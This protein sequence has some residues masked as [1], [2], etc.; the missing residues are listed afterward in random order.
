LHLLL[1]LLQKVDTPEHSALSTAISSTGAQAGGGGGGGSS[2][3]QQIYQKR[4]SSMLRK[5]QQLILT[6]FLKHQSL[7]AVLRRYRTL[8]DFQKPPPEEAQNASSYAKQ[9]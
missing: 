4:E 2:G 8:Q 3:N 7:L 9:L 1:T 6:R 5:N